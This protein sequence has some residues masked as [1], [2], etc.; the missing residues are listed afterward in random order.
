M[1]LDELILNAFS[2]QCEQF[3]RP[4]LTGRELS[5]TYGDL[6]DKLQEDGYLNEGEREVLMTNLVRRIC[7]KMLGVE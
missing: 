4:I 1:N 3:E 5:K 7:E 6:F 2:A